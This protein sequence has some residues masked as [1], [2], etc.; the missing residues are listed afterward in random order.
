MNILKLIVIRLQKTVF[1]QIK[2]FLPVNAIRKLFVNSYILPH[3]DY[4]VLLCCMGEIV[5][6]H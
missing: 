2:S 1:Q 4:P 5:Q 3:I 6:Q